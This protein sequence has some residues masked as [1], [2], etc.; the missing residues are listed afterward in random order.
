MIAEGFARIQ[1]HRNNVERYRKLLETRLTDLEREF[2]QRRL[3]EE[4]SAIESLAA[5]I[6]LLIFKDPISPQD[7][8]AA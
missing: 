6:V 5:M 2:I 7:P 3:S 8:R 4:Q 1:T